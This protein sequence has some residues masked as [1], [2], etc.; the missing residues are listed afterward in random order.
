[1]KTL[2]EPLG[3]PL[4]AI[5]GAEAVEAHVGDGLRGRVVHGHGGLMA[6]IGGVGHRD[7]LLWLMVNG[8]WLS[9]DGGGLVLSVDCSW[10]WCWSGIGRLVDI[11]A[12]ACVLLV[13]LRVGRGHRL[14]VVRDGAIEVPH[15][16]LVRVGHGVFIASVVNEPSP[17]RRQQHQEESCAQSEKLLLVCHV[18]DV[19]EV[20]QLLPIAAPTVAYKRR[21]PSVLAQSITHELAQLHC[22]P[23]PLPHSLS[24]LAGAANA[25]GFC[26]TFIN[27][28]LS[29]DR[30]KSI[31]NCHTQSDSR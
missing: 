30:G 16:I 1:M 10:S 31:Y 21:P 18:V 12:D 6:G 29:A 24:L 25:I 26:V 7:V 28:F 13:H 23:F 11:V 19:K 17:G 20:D 4:E 5:V 8:S 2:G 15:H 14:G 3:N 27:P 22:P 9:I